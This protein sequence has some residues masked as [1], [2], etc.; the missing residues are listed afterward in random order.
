MNRTLDRIKSTWAR[1]KSLN[2]PIISLPEGIERLIS[3]I[4]TNSFFSPPNF[5]GDEEKT[6]QALIINAILWTVLGLGVVITIGNIIGGRTPYLLHLVNVGMASFGLLIFFFLHRGK[7]KLASLGLIVVGITHTTLA[8]ITLGTVRTPTVTTY[9]LAVIIAGMLFKK[10]G[11]Y[12]TTAIISVILLGLV[13]AEQNGLLPTPDYSV[14]I[15]QWI[16]YTALLGFTGNLAHVALQQV[17]KILKCAET[18]LEKR[19]LIE[20]TLNIYARAIE[21]SPASIVITDAAGNIQKINPKFSRLTGYELPEALGK[22]PRILKSGEHSEE[23]YE[24]LWKTI[25]SGDEWHGEFHNKKKNGELYWEKAAISPV[26]D[27]NGF[28]TH[29][30]AVKEDITEQK[31]ASSAIEE[32]NR[33]LQAQLDQINELQVS[34]RE[35]AIRDPLTG[36]HNRRYFEEILE[37]EYERAKQGRYPISL[38]FIDL[39]NLKEINDIGGHSTG[40]HALCSVANHLRA[41]TRANDTVCRNGGDELAVIMPNVKIQDALKRA[42][43]WLSTLREITLLH[44]EGKT[45]QVTFTAG[46]ATYPD[47]SENI[48][49]VFNYADVALYR[50][51]LK[52]RNR[53]E[54]FSPE[55]SQGAL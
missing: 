49:D 12:L 52:G 14:T 23:F 10:N 19:K 1:A 6:Q 42:Q 9:M 32:A 39:D 53:V 24:Q 45:L 44:R 47:H 38:V 16:T 26:F 13:L 35:Q 30:V 34:L 55:D 51:K 20:K 17:Q 18:E 8:I 31:I 40:D 48:E 29:Y 28:V 46:I 33:R 22:N 43:E 5:P 3:A 54:I 7:I 2:K 50:G 37:K 41:H 4:R 21:H 15:T 36:L 27:E 11:I 25:S